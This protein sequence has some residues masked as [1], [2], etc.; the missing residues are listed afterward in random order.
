MRAINSSVLTI[1]LVTIPVKIYTSIKSNKVSFCQLTSNLHRVKQKWVD[2]ETGEEVNRS[3]FKRGYEYIK[4]K[5]NHPGKVIEITDED[6]KT[7]GISDSSK[8]IEINEFIPANKLSIIQIEKTY[9]LGPDN[10]GEHGYVLL[11]QVMRERNV[12][13]LAKWT[14][15]G[16]EHLVAIKP[17]KNGLLLQQLFYSDEIQDFDNVGIS[18]IQISDSEKEMAIKFIDSMTVDKFDINKYKNEYSAKILELVNKKV[19]GKAI[20]NISIPVKI[21]QQDVSQQ[22]V[23]QQDVPQQDVRNILSRLKASLNLLKNVS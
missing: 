16:H 12:I 3:T 11:S 19:N 18:N 20:D 17:Y 9:Y 23:P 10:I 2:A 1:G 8:A 5:K 4:A 22:D 15:R 21:Q 6:L 13:G 7:I 14:F